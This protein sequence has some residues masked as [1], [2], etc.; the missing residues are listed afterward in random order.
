[1]PYMKQV[2]KQLENQDDSRAQLDPSNCCTGCWTHKANKCPGTSALQTCCVHK[3][4]DSD[5][6]NNLETM[7]EHFS[8][9]SWWC[10]EWNLTVCYTTQK[11]CWISSRAALDSTQFCDILLYST[12]NCLPKIRPSNSLKIHQH[13]DYSKI[14]SKLLIQSRSVWIKGAGWAA[15]K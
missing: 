6:A 12:H 14:K 4:K 8:E 9:T 10:R 1:M 13:C 2:G 15:C 3:T 7:S 11:L 5:E